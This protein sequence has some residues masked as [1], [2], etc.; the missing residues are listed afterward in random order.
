LCILQAA[1]KASGNAEVTTA[2]SSLV[3]PDSCFL[4]EGVQHFLSNNPFLRSSVSANDLLVHNPYASDII[5]KVEALTSGFSKD[6][7]ASSELSLRARIGELQAEMVH[8]IHRMASL[9]SRWQY[10]QSELVAIHKKL[11]GFASK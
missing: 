8:D 11:D 9:Y 7:C 3:H 5:N 1:G 10:N 6:S 2:G 4:L